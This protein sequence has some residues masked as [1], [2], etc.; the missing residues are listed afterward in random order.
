M[1]FFFAW[2]GGKKFSLRFN[3]TEDMT[4]TAKR[5]GSQ[6]KYAV[7]YD[8]DGTITALDFQMV[9]EGGCSYEW[10]VMSALISSKDA[11]NW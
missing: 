11:D 4:I 7:G 5:E 2:G 10:S 9:A 8:D 6:L 1:F 3:R